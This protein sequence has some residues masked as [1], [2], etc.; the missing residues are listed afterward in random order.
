MKTM[1]MKK[2]ASARTIETYAIC[3]CVYALCTCSAC[4]CNSSTP[5]AKTS[6]TTLSNQTSGDMVNGTV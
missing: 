2:K 1:K 3:G 5:K 6:V 4:N